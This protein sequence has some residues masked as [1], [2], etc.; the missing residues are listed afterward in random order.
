MLEANRDKFPEPSELFTID[1]FGGWDKVQTDFF[2]PENG[3]I[4]EIER[5]LGNP[6][7]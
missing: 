7:E 2:D 5:E 1:D 6:T 4:V 3:S